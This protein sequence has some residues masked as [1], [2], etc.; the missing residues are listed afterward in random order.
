MQVTCPKCRARYAVDP[1]AIGPSGRT[2]QCARCNERWFETV[3]VA[4][5]PP[6]SSSPP[7]SP[8]VA[9]E[10]RTPLPPRRRAWYALW[11][12]A[13]PEAAPQ[14]TKPEN[15]SPI[16]PTFGEPTLDMAPRPE[17]APIPDVVIR[18]ATRG[19]MLPA[20]IEP[21]TNRHINLV[22]LGG[23]LL[24]VLAAAGVL[25]YHDQI[26]AYVPPEWRALLRI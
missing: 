24:V 13:Q 20:L 14:D 8:L 25:A 10:T 15:E 7:V 5:A 6:P 11:Q 9:A 23:G 4:P 22:L 2:V 3:K 17:I 18:P 19:S 1:L 21:K 16:E 26:L 12:K